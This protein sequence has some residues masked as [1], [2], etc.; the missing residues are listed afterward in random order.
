MQNNFLSPLLPRCVP[1]LKLDAAVADF[2]RPYFEVYPNRGNETRLERLLCIS[3]LGYARPASSAGY[4][5]RQVNVVRRHR[6][7]TSQKR[8]NRHVL[9]TE[10]FPSSKIFT[11]AS[12][13]QGRAWLQSTVLTHTVRKTHSVLMPH[14]GLA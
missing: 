4:T 7:R 1:D 5:Q 14:P 2:N 6:G 11:S 12:S 9:P 3:A 13:A 10:L 8:I